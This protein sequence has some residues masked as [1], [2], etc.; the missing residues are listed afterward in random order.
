MDS[1]ASGLGTA[2]P[3]PATQLIHPHPDAT[4]TDARPV[5]LVWLSAVV[6][7]TS[8]VCDY[9]VQVS[10]NSPKLNGSFGS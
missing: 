4:N 9:H 3:N 6:Y 1:S 10:S 2:D 5:R 8:I 7:A